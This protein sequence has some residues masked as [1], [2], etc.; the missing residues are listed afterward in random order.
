MRCIVPG[1]KE[2]S[3]HIFK[4]ICYL[5][6]LKERKASQKVNTAVKKVDKD[7]KSLLLFMFLPRHISD[8]STDDQ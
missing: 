5:S 2:C 6:Y 3:V 1:H 4:Q 8:D 7:E